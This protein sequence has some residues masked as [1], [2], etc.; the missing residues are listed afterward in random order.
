MRA[1]LDGTGGQAQGDHL[2]RRLM[3]LRHGRTAW[4]RESRAQGQ[5]DVALD[6]TG[7]AQAAAVATYL[8]ALRPDA[9]WTSDLLRARQTCAYL[10]TATGLVARTDPRLREFDVGL[11]QGLTAPEFADAHPREHA[12]WAAGDPSHPIPG[13]ESDA[14][15]EARMRPVVQEALD[16]LEPGG[17]AVL[18]THGAS[19]KIAVPVLLGLPAELARALRGVDNC[20]W[21]ALEEVGSSRRLRL[22]GYNQAVTGAGFAS[23]TPVG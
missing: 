21:V 13:A 18:V 4:N 14:E 2:G 16:E 19:L 3:L 17:T 20:A 9:L 15:V 22:T 7:H 11:R 5:A 6:E 23:P 1:D 10:E 8:G 12:A